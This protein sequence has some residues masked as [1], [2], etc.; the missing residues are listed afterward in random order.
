VQGFSDPPLQA[1][2]FWEKQRIMINQC[3]HKVGPF[4]LFCPAELFADA[5]HILGL[6]EL[7]LVSILALDVSVGWVSVSSD[8]PAFFT[9]PIFGLG[10]ASTVCKIHIVVLPPR[11]CLVLFRPP[12]QLSL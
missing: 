4:K 5:G 8:Y 2:A 10:T 6:S 9:C 3:V 12:A 1:I 7:I 11:E